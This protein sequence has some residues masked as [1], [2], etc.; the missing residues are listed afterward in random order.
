MTP[1]WKDG[2]FAML[3]AARL[4][5]DIATNDKERQIVAGLI[6]TALR[7]MVMA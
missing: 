3:R 2:I 4:G 1:I 5:G 7:A 6:Q